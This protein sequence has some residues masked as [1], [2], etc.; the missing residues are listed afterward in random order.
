MYEYKVEFFPVKSELKEEISDSYLKVCRFCEKEVEINTNNIHKQSIKLNPTEFYCDFCYRNNFHINKPKVF[1]FSLKAI[2]FH[3]YEN[4]YIKS[5][6]KSIWL[7]QLDEMIFLH[8][9]SGLNNLAFIYDEQNFN[10]FID[11]Q[12]FSDEI[13]SKNFIFKTI[14]EMLICFNLWNINVDQVVIFNFIKNAIE[15]TISNNIFNI[16]IP[17]YGNQKITSKIKNFSYNDLKVKQII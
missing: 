4:F 5:S 10:W 11:L 14:I 8:K 1:V 3:Y 2:I 15:N 16:C 12:K 17:P 9:E 7:S 6:N 13:S